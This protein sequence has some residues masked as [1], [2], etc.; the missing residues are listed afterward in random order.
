MP[1]ETGQRT[2]ATITN[3]GREISI[4][5][6]SIFKKKKRRGFR[7]LV[8]LTKALDMRDT[9]TLIVHRCRLDIVEDPYHRY[10]SSYQRKHDPIKQTDN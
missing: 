1:L 4:T 9:C 2:T 6:E 5:F 3:K 7:G 8:W 10:T